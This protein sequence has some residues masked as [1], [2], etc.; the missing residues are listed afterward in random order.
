VSR[1]VFAVVAHRPD[2]FALYQAQVRKLRG[3]AR[4]HSRENG[5][6]QARVGTCA[7]AAG[8][9]LTHRDAVAFVLQHGSQHRWS[10]A[11]AV[12]CACP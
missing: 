7:Q 2:A 9:S 4:V 1:K 5:I 6:V 10:Q 11:W 3:L 12:G 8:L